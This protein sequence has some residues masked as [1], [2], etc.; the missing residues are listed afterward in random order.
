M[1]DTKISYF[2]I[3]VNSPHKDLI[4]IKGNEN[5]CDPIF[6][7][8]R[9][10]LS[11]NQNIHVKKVKLSL[12]GELSVTYFEKD[13]NGAVTNHILEKFITLKVDWDNLLINDEG[14][15]VLGSYGDK[16][17][18]AYKAGKLQAH[19][20]LEEMKQES[21]ARPT[22]DRTKSQPNLSKA[23][24]KEAPTIKLPTSGIDGTPFK[25]S[26]SHHS[27]LLPNGNYSLPFKVVLPTNICETVEGLAIGKLLYKFEGSI[28]KGMLFDKPMVKSKYMRFVRTLHPNSLSLVDNIDI[29]NTWPGKVD[30]KVYLNK[31]GVAIGSTIP[32]QVLIVPLV[33]GISLKKIT[34]EVVQHCH[35]N[36][37]EGRS[38]EF[39]QVFGHQQV[40]G[41]LDESILSQDSWNL[42]CHFKVPNSIKEVTQTCLLNNDLIQVRHRLRVTIQIR[43][44]GGHTSELRANLPITL[45]ISSTIGHV[46]GHHFE[47]DNH[48]G[49]F[50]IVRNKDDALFKRDKFNTPKVSPSVTP[51]V[52]PDI[53]PRHSPTL[54]PLDDTLDEEDELENVLAPPLYE[55]SKK[56]KIFDI[57]SAKS[58]IE[59]LGTSYFDLPRSNSEVM[60]GSLDLNIL[61]KVPSY[62]EA[63]DDDDDSGDLAP[64]YDNSFDAMIGS[65][66]SQTS[67]PSKLSKNASSSSLSN[68]YSHRSP[69]HSRSSSKFNLNFNR[70]KDKPEKS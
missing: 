15:I 25:N 51:L 55:E 4:V 18:K 52:S 66:S 31:K 35:V 13:E 16:P 24:K 57:T 44:P 60:S 10:K 69:L 1:V 43:N 27:F 47:I 64:S 7:E 34:T 8:G 59:Q 36:Y 65:N 53:T 20:H 39:E 17:V 58:P 26:S 29:V 42:T 19:S 70:K 2:D 23:H 54:F 40:M 62:F 67:L 37:L 32:I 45:Y 63:V 50:N 6:L 28:Q 12:I 46:Y 41:P 33:K 5:E 30:Y 61:S 68:S 3:R 49:L 48:H 56:D 9:V 21:R 14:T 22:F 11:V 38:P